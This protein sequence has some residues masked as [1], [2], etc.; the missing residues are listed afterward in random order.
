MFSA[1]GYW[2]RRTEF[3]ATIK[4]TVFNPFRRFCGAE[5]S[6]M[7]KIISIVVVAFISLVA[8]S[9]SAQGLLDT[10]EPTG[11]GPAAPNMTVG[12]LAD[13][14][15]GQWAPNGFVPRFRNRTDG[16]VIGEAPWFPPT[17]KW[18]VKDFP[19]KEIISFPDY[20]RMLVTSTGKSLKDL[21]RTS[22]KPTVANISVNGK[23]MTVQF[24]KEVMATSVAAGSFQ[25]KEEAS[26]TAVSVTSATMDPRDPS[27]RSVV[28]E[29]TQG[30]NPRKTYLVEGQIQYAV[31]EDSVEPLGLLQ[32]SSD[33]SLKWHTCLEAN[34]PKAHES[35]MNAK[36]DPLVPTSCLVK[37]QF[38]K[39]GSRF[40]LDVMLA[41]IQDL[42]GG[43]PEKIRF[44]VENYGL[45][46]DQIKRFSNTAYMVVN[47]PTMREGMI[48][49]FRIVEDDGQKR[50]Q[51]PKAIVGP[52][53][54]TSPA[55]TQGQDGKG[56]SG[57]FWALLLLGLLAWGLVAYVIAKRLSGGMALG[58]LAIIA[59]AV[60]LVTLFIFD[61][62][63]GIWFVVV[64]LC[65]GIAAT[66]VLSIKRGG[67]EAEASASE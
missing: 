40:F 9:A 25:V 46:G 42:G 43:E 39:E 30:L 15:E 50:I 44:L 48:D 38:R 5:V 7:Q 67:G 47:S 63:F 16:I 1:M 8:V 33:P 56:S 57:V 59:I 12:E 64:A 14:L 29:T 18:Q 41:S 58:R 2:L 60:G 61:L 21:K 49:I 32:R 3:L 26:G 66:I 31:S 20:D 28:L 51:D 24:T 4:F 34:P 23:K 27:K 35:G 10:E 11:G 17:V 22:G 62:I 65:L 45:K 55:S 54:P 36:F 37:F 53:T 52:A 19:P 6:A 13:R